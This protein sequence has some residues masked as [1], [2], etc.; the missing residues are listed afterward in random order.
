MIE[1]DMWESYGSTISIEIESTSPSFLCNIPLFLCKLLTTYGQIYSGNRFEFWWMSF[2]IFSIHN[3]I[4]SMS[5]I[6][7]DM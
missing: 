5:N 6:I 2:S 7:V 3:G 1:N 4:Y